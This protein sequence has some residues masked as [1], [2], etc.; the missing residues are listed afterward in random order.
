MEV[1]GIVPVTKVPF[2]SGRTCIDN[3]NFVRTV[4][5]YSVMIK[6][7]NVLHESSFLKLLEFPYVV[8]IA[9][10]KHKKMNVCW[11]ILCVMR[12]YLESQ[13]NTCSH[14]SVSTCICV[15]DTE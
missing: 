2:P 1:Q 14:T 6:N 10:V 3:D 12:E 15:D 11:L 9:Y 5:S 8:K 13:E 7:K 4:I